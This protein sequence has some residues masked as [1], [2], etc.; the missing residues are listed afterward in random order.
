MKV[1]SGQPVKVVK[2]P[3]QSKQAPASTKSI[4]GIKVVTMYPVI[5]DRKRQSPQ[6]FYLNIDGTDKRSVMKFQMFANEKGANLD[7]DGL[8]T[9]KDGAQS[10]TQKAYNKYGAEW[11]ASLKG[12]DPSRDASA[13]ASSA[14]QGGNSS[15]GDGVKKPKTKA[16]K[17]K[18]SLWD[19]IKGSGLVDKGLGALGLGGDK[20]GDKG[21]SGLGDASVST[22]KP[23]EDP[24]AK[25]GMSTGVKVAIASAVVLTVLG[26]VYFASKKK[27]APA[28]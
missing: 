13:L 16:P 14:S 4:S 9:R 3:T 21:G 25:K 18:T 2:K 6:D 24:A 8:F 27:D 26:I 5:V 28:K 11:E 17:D 19:K 10:E 12:N 7:V 15:Q 1:I 20:G 23:Y 22:D